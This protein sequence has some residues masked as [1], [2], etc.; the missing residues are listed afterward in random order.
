MVSNNRCISTRELII[1]ISKGISRFYSFIIIDRKIEATYLF[2]V[3]LNVISFDFN[4][5]Q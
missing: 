5:K 4:A 3:L 1:I 2:K